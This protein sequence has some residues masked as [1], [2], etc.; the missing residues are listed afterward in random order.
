LHQLRKNLD[1]R[2]SRDLRDDASERPMLVLLPCQAV[3]EDA[4]VGGDKRSRGF[5][6][7]GFNAEDQAHA[8]SCSRASR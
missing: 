4:S 3:R 8:L 2:A 6:A 7:A 5:V 1:M